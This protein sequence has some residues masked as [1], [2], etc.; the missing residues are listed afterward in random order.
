MKAIE[1]PQIIITTTLFILLALIALVLLM[2]GCVSERI[3]GNHD[4]ITQDRPSQPFS[5]VVS[6]GSFSVKIIPS[7]ETRIEVK[8]ES[9]VLPY[10]ST[11]S[12]GTTLTIKY[13]DGYNIHEHY[14]VEI[15][16]YTDVLNAVS[17]SGSGTVDC[18]YFESNEMYLNI[19]GSGG[20]TGD[21]ETEN[22]EAVISGSGN[23]NLAGYSNTGLFSIS[24][25]G[26][27]NAQNLDLEHCSANISGS[28]NIN[29]Y[30]IKTLDA[31]ISGSGSIFYYGNPVVK[32][33]IS[34]S[35]NVVKY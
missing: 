24:G 13:N 21:F 4:V 35:G 9:N 15:F 12:N 18:G 28:G 26:N 1:K 22:L 2:S 3:E 7:D 5:E 34:G 6:S 11:Y 10:L 16:L 8:G 33:H 23:M 27:I 31:T 17:L 20:I 25:S 32:T 29:T 14:P 30:V 19:S